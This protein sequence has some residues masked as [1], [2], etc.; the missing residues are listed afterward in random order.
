MKTVILPTIQA[1]TR[2]Q[3]FCC[4]FLFFLSCCWNN[5]LQAQVPD[6]ILT[7]EQSSAKK[8]PP[9][10]HPLQVSLLPFL[11]TAA[12]GNRA[13]VLSFNVLLGSHSNVYGLEF[14]GLGNILKRH[15]YGVQLAGLFNIVGARTAG[16]QA[17]GLFNITGDAVHGIQATGIF[18]LAKQTNGLQ[19]SGIFNLTQRLNGLQVAGISNMS[20]RANGA[21]IGGISNLAQRVNGLQLA[22]TVNQTQ[23]LNGLQAAGLINIA[24]RVR[25]AQIGLMNIGKRV[26]GAQIGLINI[27]DSLNG[28]TIG[29]LNIVRKNGYNHFEVSGGETMHLTL[30]FKFGTPY[31]YN[32]VEVST[33]ILFQNWAYAYGFGT[34]I[35]VS[36]KWKLN[37]ELA[38]RQINEGNWFTPE[39]NLT[40]QLRI[41]GTY[42]F[43]KGI[44]LF[45]G[46]TFNLHI[47]NL[48]NTD[49]GTYGS[50]L[51]P[52]AIYDQTNGT[53][54]L[55]FW[56]G[57]RVGLRF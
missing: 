10:V 29:L 26:D 44:A 54:N 14:G 30:G 52:Y 57:G 19:S 24:Q 21:Q 33:T 37:L 35:G 4:L 6:E 47:S 28:A 36:K 40:N 31:F 49:T 32:L 43:K 56:I 51:M 3:L 34:A 50:N 55:K 1:F 7:E 23:E 38:A 11:G 25:G 9:K 45:F 42:Q 13:Y 46:P 20:S 12:P 2:Q 8:T 17:S 18:N 53:T 5:G 41:W 15:L 48:Y 22:S 39:L 16:L 27:V